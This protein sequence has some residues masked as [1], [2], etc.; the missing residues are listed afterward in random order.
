M[1]SQDDS[2]SSKTSST[3]SAE[4]ASSAGGKDRL[5]NP[6]PKEN[7]YTSKEGRKLFLNHR[8][9]EAGGPADCAVCGEE[10]PGV[11]LELL[12]EENGEK[13]RR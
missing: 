13:T 5:G 7:Y 12:V 1:T 2:I 10:D 11:A 6:H 4:P 9:A 8:E 3:S